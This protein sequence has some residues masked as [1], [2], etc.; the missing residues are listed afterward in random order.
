MAVRIPL[1]K[2]HWPRSIEEW[3]SLHERLGGRLSLVL[4]DEQT[5]SDPIGAFN[6]STAQWK[7]FWLEYPLAAPIPKPRAPAPTDDRVRDF[8][9]QLAR[10]SAKSW[11][12]EIQNASRRR[13]T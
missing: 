9:R 7:E 2:S 13:Q 11:V 5:H 4:V 12:K 10:L 1:P 6:S 3:Q 8:L